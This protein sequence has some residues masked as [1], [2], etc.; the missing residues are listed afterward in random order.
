MSTITISPSVDPQI[1]VSVEGMVAGQPAT[2]A[3]LNAA[4]LTLLDGITTLNSSRGVA[5]SRTAPDAD[6]LLV[7]LCD[8]VSEPI[9]NSGSAGEDGNLNTPRGGVT[10]GAVGLYSDCLRFIPKLSET[11]AGITGGSYADVPSGVLSMS[12]WCLPAAP[13]T[14][15]GVIA[16]CQHNSSTWSTA[17]DIGW[18]WESSGDGAWR[19]GIRVAGVLY[20]YSTIVASGGSNAPLDV[21]AWNLLSVDWDLSTLNIYL[22]GLL[23]RSAVLIGAGVDWG[24]ARSWCIGNRCQ[25]SDVFE[26]C[27]G[28]VRVG[29]IVRGVAYWKEMYKTGIGRSY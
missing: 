17:Y 9:I 29:Q 28:D 11:S 24:P 18:H 8:D 6:D 19:F 12:C 10:F 26:G 14:G 4:L 16:L 1:P 2:S 22:N 7:W 21:G 20:E 25:D 3:D 13:Q 15:W 27:I 5:P 23:I